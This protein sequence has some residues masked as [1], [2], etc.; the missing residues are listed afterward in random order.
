MRTCPADAAAA[1]A[2]A[3]LRPA[4]A[5]ADAAAAAPGVPLHASARVPAG[6]ILRLICSKIT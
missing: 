1:A 2:V 6:E 3:A 5:A 4:S